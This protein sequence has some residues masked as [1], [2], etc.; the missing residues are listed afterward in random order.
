LLILAILA[1][2]IVAGWLAQL[3]LGRRT[4]NRGEA[5]VAGLV[6]SF[7]GGLLASSIAGSG[8]AIRPSGV[9]GS[10]VGA[11]IVLVVWN[12]IRSLR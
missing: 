4:S 10:A 7:V 5:L 2:G 9:I 11:I 1:I 6:G 12:W 8:F 3:I